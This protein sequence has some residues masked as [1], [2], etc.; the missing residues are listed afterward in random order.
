MTRRTINLKVRERWNAGHGNG[1]NY[2]IK[3]G[4][5]E[6]TAD[7]QALLKQKRNRWWIVTGYICFNPIPLKPRLLHVDKKYLQVAITLTDCSYN[8]QQDC[9]WLFN[10]YLQNPKKLK[11]QFCGFQDIIPLATW[12]LDIPFDCH[13][14]SCTWNTELT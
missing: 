4:I 13:S 11:R 6:T 8:A 12:S 3:N 7:T 2:I 10:K 14:Q 9:L 5:H 1:N